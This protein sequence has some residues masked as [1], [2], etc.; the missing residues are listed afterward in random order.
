[1]FLKVSAFC[2]GRG[3]YLIILCSCSGIAFDNTQADILRW[4]T[5]QVIPGTEGITVGPEVRLRLWNTDEHN[6]RYADLSG[7]LV[8]TRSNFDQSWLDHATF[9]EASL[10]RSKLRNASLENSDL[11]SADLNRADLQGA[12]LTNAIL[13]DA[14][15]TDAD[16]RDVTLQNASLIRANLTESDLRRGPTSTER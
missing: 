2:C 7:G 8:L 13:N 4:D 9:A 12:T 1:M 3:V 6:L 16:L 5:G 10:I 14:D 11:T 15:L